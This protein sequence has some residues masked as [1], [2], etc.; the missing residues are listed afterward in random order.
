MYGSGD[1]AQEGLRDVGIGGTDC[2][3]VDNAAMQRRMQ[4]WCERWRLRGD[5]SGGIEKMGSNTRGGCMYGVGWG[6][7]VW[8]AKQKA[9][10]W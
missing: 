4:E 10:G 1:L 9:V 8:R 2:R 3:R 5:A 7:A 6:N